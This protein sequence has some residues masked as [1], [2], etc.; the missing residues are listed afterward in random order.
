MLSLD[1]TTKDPS[2]T[3]LSEASQG[4]KDKYV[5][6]FSVGIKPLVDQKDLEDTTSKPS[7]VYII[8]SDQLASTGERIADILNGF[9]QDPIPESGG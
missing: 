7:N 3:P 1:V 9:V 5:K 2:L 8:A 6:I 4:L